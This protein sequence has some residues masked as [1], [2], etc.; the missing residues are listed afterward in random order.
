MKSFLSF[1]VIICWSFS[2]IFNHGAPSRD[3]VMGFAAKPPELL[4]IP[5]V[6]RDNI[7][8][9]RRFTGGGTVIVDQNTIFASLIFNVILFRF[10][11]LFLLFLK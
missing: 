4:N 10:H 8:V 9:I 2:V 11:F 3:I 1:L 5:E 6:L 7:P